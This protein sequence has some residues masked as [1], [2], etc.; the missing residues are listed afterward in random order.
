MARGFFITFEGSEGCGKSTHMRSLA[1]YFEGLG[2]E[3]VL[4]R[5][6]GG[7]ELS[8]KIR[9]LLLDK[10]L[11]QM[12][13][14]TEILLFEAARAEHVDKLIKPSLE[15]GKIVISDRFYDSTSAYQGAARLIGADTVK[16][17]NSFATDSLV[18]DITIVLDIDAREGLE[19][20]GRRDNGDTDRMGSEK[21]EFYQKVREG[22]LEL[23]RG[24]P[25]RFAVVD[26]S[27]SK[28]ETFSKILAAVEEKLR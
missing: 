7:T 1:K 22:F 16:Y 10:S 13:A 11:G 8:E 4:T 21:L 17:L 28:E 3:C 15:Q 23:A 18:P 9:A 6:P 20:A 2:R 27:G 26:S 12:S 14:R 19:R 5:E 25:E 24:E